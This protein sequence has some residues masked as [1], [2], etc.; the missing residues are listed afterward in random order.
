MK[1]LHK[2]L[3]GLM[4]VLSVSGCATVKLVTAVQSQGY[5]GVWLPVDMTKTNAPSGA[6]LVNLLCE[7]SAKVRLIISQYGTPD[8]IRYQEIAF[9]I[10][11]GS[12]VFVKNNQFV[13][14]DKQIDE[15]K[16]QSLD[17]VYE[18]ELP[19]QYV[20]LLKQ[21]ASDE[22]KA[23]V[24]KRQKEEAE[25]E[26]RYKAELAQQQKERADREAKY[27]AELA[28]QQKELA[29]REAL[30]QKERADREAV[31]IAKKKAAADEALKQ[32][33]A[34][35]KEIAE[36]TKLLD[37][38]TLTKRAD[39]KKSNTLVF[40]KLY[41]GMPIA[42]CLQ[43]INYS[44]GLPQRLPTPHKDPSETADANADKNPNAALAGFMLGGLRAQFGA[45]EDDN[46]YVVYSSKGVSFIAKDINDKP[47]AMADAS[48]LITGFQLSPKILNKFFESANQP[49]E[50]FLKAFMN[51][52]NIPKLEPETTKVTATL[53]GTTQE[54]GYQNILRYRAPDGYEVIYHDVT[55]L[56]KEGAEAFAD[57]LPEGSMTIR[58]IK[59]EQERGA[60]F[61]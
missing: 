14:Y 54:L 11:K 19:P 41:L 56:E 31:E 21:K 12:F 24:E 61:N 57:T 18:S 46:S 60:K 58:K 59:T 38:N 43:L 10:F 47:F 20:A 33:E 17:R 37:I 30:A 52:Y 6:H 7:S 26:A 45:N 2:L 44:M 22:Q 9:D 28:Q 51:A 1:S 49:K 48:G 34:E 15:Q 42:D 5:N 53:L 39:A 4:V 8:Y 55:I 36:A 29:D 13:T 27:K 40:K 25:R 50:E 35:A 23:L 32:K 16:A 3:F